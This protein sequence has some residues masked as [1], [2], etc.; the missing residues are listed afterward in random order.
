MIRAKY[1]LIKTQTNCARP[2]CWA[3]WAQLGT[4]YPARPTLERAPAQTASYSLQPH[5]AANPGPLHTPRRFSQSNSNSCPAVPPSANPET[6]PP[7]VHRPQS[8]HP[9]LS[10]L[11]LSR[12]A[13]AH[14]RTCLIGAFLAQLPVGKQ[15][16]L[17]MLLQFYLSSWS[18]RCPEAAFLVK[19]GVQTLTA[20]SVSSPACRMK[21]RICTTLA[22]LA[23]LA[24]AGERGSGVC[25]PFLVML[26]V[27]CF[28]D[29]QQQLNPPLHPTSMQGSCPTHT[30]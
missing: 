17:Q 12:Y 24:T 13:C 9:H 19:N 22:L 7:R 29:Q 26:A 28:R 3:A 5:N 10:L 23:A 15:K 20:I 11:I 4:P 21:L 27:C 2:A 30:L 8:L 1:R 14:A 18:S 16:K 25:C 6:A